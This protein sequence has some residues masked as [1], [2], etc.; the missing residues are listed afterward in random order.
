MGVIDFA[1]KPG[2]IHFGIKQEEGGRFVDY[3]EDLATK[4]G[5]KTLI[6]DF[7]VDMQAIAHPGVVDRAQITTDGKHL[8]NNFGRISKEIGRAFANT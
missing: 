3:L 7:P 1:D 2:H 6:S 4:C 5:Y 8:V